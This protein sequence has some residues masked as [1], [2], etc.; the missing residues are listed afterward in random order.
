MYIDS[1]EKKS[2]LFKFFRFVN[3]GFVFLSILSDTKKAQMSINFGK[4][5]DI[6][7]KCFCLK[8]FKILYLYF[9]PKYLLL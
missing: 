3:S 4:M 9:V 8:D 5:N 1:Y 6:F 2:Q 7:E